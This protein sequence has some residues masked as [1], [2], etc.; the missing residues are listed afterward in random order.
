MAQ[1]LETAEEEL[2]AANAEDLRAAE[3]LSEV[4][5]L[6]PATIARL[7]LSKGKL[8]EMVAQIRSVAALADPLDRVLDAMELDDAGGVAAG[9]LRLQKISVPLGVLAVIFE[10]RPDAVTQIASLAL[11]SGNAGER[12]S[13]ARCGVSGTG[14]SAC[15]RVAGDA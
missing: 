8:H 9:G 5:R 15:E 11:K 14:T 3:G 7:E 2:L 6:A 12:G 10:A 1:A 4:E 13:S